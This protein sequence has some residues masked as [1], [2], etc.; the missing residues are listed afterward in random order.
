GDVI[1]KVEGQSTEGMSTDQ[2]R[3][4]I[5][6]KPGTAV[7][8]LVRRGA[9]TRDPEEIS[10]TRAKIEMHVADGFTRP[11]ADP[12]GWGYFP[13][14][15]N[16]IAMIRLTGYNTKTTKELKAALEQV[17]REGAKALVLDLRDYPGGLLHEAVEVADLF[18][19]GGTSVSTR[20]RSGGGRSWA[21]K[22]DKSPW[23]R[24][25]A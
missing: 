3:K 25:T 13:D 4:L 12:T 8:M 17:E 14:K 19:A 1:L 11:P 18:L 16:K 6:G 21:A 10:L 5:T 23:E 20:D 22:D 15:A 7:K 24:R 2:A 9:G